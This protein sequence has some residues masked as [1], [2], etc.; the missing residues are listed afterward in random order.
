MKIYANLSEEGRA[1]PEHDPTPPCRVHNVH[2]F[3]R[4]LSVGDEP[5][6]KT[7]KHLNI[8]IINESGACRRAS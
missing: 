7:G 1:E 3:R 8:V 5:D 2:Q 6:F 4:A